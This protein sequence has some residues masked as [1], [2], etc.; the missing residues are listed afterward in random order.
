MRYGNTHH[1]SIVAIH[2]NAHTHTH[3]HTHTHSHTHTHTHTHTQINAHTHTHTHTL[4]HK[5]T[6]T[7]MHAHTRIPRKHCRHTKVCCGIESAHLCGCVCVCMHAYVCAILNQ[8]MVEGMYVLSLLEEDP[9]RKKAL[10]DKFTEVVV[11]HSD[12][13]QPG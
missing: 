10:V 2:T 7:H 4:T 3:T 1:S 9:E 5:C 6:L 8:L 11:N 12:H 13:F